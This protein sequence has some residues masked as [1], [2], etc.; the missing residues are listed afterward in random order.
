MAKKYKDYLTVVLDVDAKWVTDSLV[1]DRRVALYGVNI[2]ISQLGNK[3]TIDPVIPCIGPLI[4][5]VQK[6]AGKTQF[7]FDRKNRK[8]GVTL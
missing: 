5:L 6:R 7:R 2:A 8:W 4:R 1:K 3:L